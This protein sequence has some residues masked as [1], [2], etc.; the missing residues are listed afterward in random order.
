ME[1]K[2]RFFSGFDL[3]VILLVVLAV[4]GW[5]W[6]NNRPVDEDVLVF[7]GSPAIYYIEVN[8]ITQEQASQVQVGD[9]LLEGARHFP[10]GEVIAIEVRPFEA[11][12]E[13]W[14]NETISFQ[15]V[16]ERY[17]MVLTVQT[18]VEETEQEVLTEGG[19]LI[20]GGRSIN[21]T[22]PGYAFVGGVI[23]RIERGS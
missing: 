15:V 22:G 3:C 7:H 11:R 2:R 20:R 19:V 14:T 5:L 10:I 6:L 8:N 1:E 9:N 23:L 13:D 21:F 16:P 17:T 4:T 12:V 18:M